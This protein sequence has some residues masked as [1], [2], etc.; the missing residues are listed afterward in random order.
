MKIAPVDYMPVM[1]T[2]PTNDK[3]E[4]TDRDC[5]FFDDRYRTVLIA[6]IVAVIF[7]GIVD[8]FLDYIY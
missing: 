8:A 1:Q 6:T 5:T 2:P 3:K 7:V 4:Q